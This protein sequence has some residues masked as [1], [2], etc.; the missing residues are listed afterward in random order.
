MAG[1]LKPHTEELDFERTLSIVGG[2][3]ALHLQVFVAGDDD[4]VARRLEKLL[5]SSSL[6]KRRG[7]C[8]PRSLTASPLV[9]RRKSM[10]TS[11]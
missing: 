6:Q 8:S 7:D 1:S 2:I 4:V 5:K 9:R 10:N 3:L 11:F